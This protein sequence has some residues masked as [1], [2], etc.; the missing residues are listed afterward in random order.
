[1]CAVYSSAI[2]CMLYI[3]AGIVVMHLPE[4]LRI[5]PSRCI[6]IGIASVFRL[7]I[8][9]TSIYMPY[10]ENFAVIFFFE[11]KHCLFIRIG[12]SI[13]NH[14]YSDDLWQ[15]YQAS[16]VEFLYLSVLAYHR[17]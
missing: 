4:Y 14:F 2:L 3:F 7:Q 13:I 16:W 10:F 11:E 6:L 17:A 15:I 5:I 12:I 9:V 1:M 8:R